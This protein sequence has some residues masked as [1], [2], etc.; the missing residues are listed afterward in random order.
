MVPAPGN[1]GYTMI[2][3]LGVVYPFGSAPFLGSFIGPQLIN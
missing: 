1:G 2:D 3:T